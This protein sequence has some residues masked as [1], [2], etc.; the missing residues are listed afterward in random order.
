MEYRDFI[1]NLSILGFENQQIENALESIGISDNYERVFNKDFLNRTS[2][3]IPDST[4]DRLFKY[5]ANFIQKLYSYCEKKNI[6]IIV[7]SD[8]NYPEKLRYI[9]NSPKIL[10]AIGDLSL[11]ETKSVAIVG[12]RK[13]SN[14]GAA[15]VEYIVNSLKNKGVTVISGLAYGIDALSHKHALEKDIRTIGILGGGVDIV[16]PKSNEYLYNKIIEKNLLISEYAPGSYPKPY[17][18]PLRNR[19]ISGLSEAVVI[20]EARSKSGSLITARLAAEQGREV[21]AVPG[22]INSIYSEGTNL[23]IR[24]GAQILASTD[25]LLFCLGCDNSTELSNSNRF[26]DLGEDERKI[27]DLINSGVNEISLIAMKLKTDVSVINSI[28]TILEIKDLVNIEG[29]YISIKN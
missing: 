29:E 22:N 15:V 12:S 17:R 9:E 27:L 28:M 2:I 6:S 23:L 11:L 5:N 1:I 3:K 19:I 13:H 21:F 24:D 8:Q 4:K 18:F 7:D 25:D 20:V 10:Y 26:K 16:Y 14:Y